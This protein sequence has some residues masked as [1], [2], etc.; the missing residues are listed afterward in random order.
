MFRP[1][2]AVWMALIVLGGVSGAIAQ[3]IWVGGGG[4]GR[5]A[6]RWAK[7]TDFDGSFLYCRGFYQSVRREPGGSGWS[8]DYPGADNNFSVRLAELTTV[9]VRLDNN[10]QPQHVV[11]H[12]TDPLLFRCPVIFMEDMGTAEFSPVEVE[13]LREY[14]FKGGFLWVDDFWGS[15][16]WSAWTEQIGRV[17]PAREFPIVDL[18]MTHPL[19]HTLYDVK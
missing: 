4:Y 10:R 9:R 2:L 13:R 18:P 5:Y 16:A 14:F 8:T 15:R 12:L 7:S 6:P 3:Q 11:V 1:R 17:L 19:L